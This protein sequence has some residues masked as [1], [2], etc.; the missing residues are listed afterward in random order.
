MPFDHAVGLS[1]GAHLACLLGTADKDTG[2]E[3]TA[4]NLDQSSRVQC[5]VDFFGP[6]DLSLFAES[7]GFDGMFRSIFGATYRDKP[8]TYKKASPVEYATKDA[9]PFLILHGTTDLIVPIIHSERLCDKLAKAGAKAELITVKGGFHGQ[10][11]DADNRS[12]TAAT[13]DFLTRELK[14]GK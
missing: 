6:A 4:G 11:D 14:R 3:G 8:E 1:A 7:P 12:T 5:V 10:W 13:V 9:P 2:L